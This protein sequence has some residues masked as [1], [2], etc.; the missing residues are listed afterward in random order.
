MPPARLPPRA[1]RNQPTNRGH[2]MRES[3][4]DADVTNPP[5]IVGTVQRCRAELEAR[6][7]ALWGRYENDCR[8][9]LATGRDLGEALSE[10]RDLC[11]AGEWLPLLERLGIPRRTVSRLVKKFKTP[12]EEDMGQL[13][14]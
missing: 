1:S 2:S 7:T 14:Q 6:A 8:R 3:V 5:A 4:F 11:G 10:L 9:L 13:A 12:P